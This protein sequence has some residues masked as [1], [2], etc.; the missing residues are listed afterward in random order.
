[1]Q[2]TSA[3]GF[4]T[5]IDGLLAVANSIAGVVDSIIPGVP[6]FGDRPIALEHGAGQRV[7][8]EHQDINGGLYRIELSSQLAFWHQTAFQLSH[9]LAH[10]KMG[11]ARSNVLLEVLATAVA[12]E[13]FVRLEVRW[14]DSPPFAWSGWPDYARRLKE[15]RNKTIA[16]ELANLTGSI[17]QCFGSQAVAEKELRLCQVRSSI[18]SLPLTHPESRA[19][20]VMAADILA[21]TALSTGP[22]RWADLLGLATQTQ[23]TAQDDPRY[24]E[25]LALLGTA[26]PSWVPQ[27]LR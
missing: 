15:T 9:E 21:K 7:F 25:D 14:V 4:G 22:N 16:D 23:P 18:G 27:W 11:P 1:M 10:V 17:R 13:C 26:V 2:V 12:F 8:W 3:T 6:P 24:R 5:T 19:W 20:Q